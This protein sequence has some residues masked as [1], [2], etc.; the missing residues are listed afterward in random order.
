[1]SFPFDR[2]HFLRGSVALGGTLLADGVPLHH[3][4]AAAPA[5][6]EAPVVDRLVKGGASPA[7]AIEVLYVSCLSRRPTADENRLLSEY[8]AKRGDPQSGYAGVL[9]ILLNSSE[10]ALN[11]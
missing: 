9:W 11:H 1:M 7:E 5:R 10:F 6:V 4:G 3:A 8:V 2:R